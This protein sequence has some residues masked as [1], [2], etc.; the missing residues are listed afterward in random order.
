MLC[1]NPDKLISLEDATFKAGQLN[2]QPTTRMADWHY[3]V[4]DYYTKKHLERYPMKTIPENRYFIAVVGDG[5][6]IGTI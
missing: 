2:G 4:R 3:E 1:P 5:E 6:D